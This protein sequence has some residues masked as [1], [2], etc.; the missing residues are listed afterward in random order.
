MFLLS[1]LDFP[2]VSLLEMVSGE[3]NCHPM[4]PIL[5]CPVYLH[6]SNH[7]Q[8]HIEGTAIQQHLDPGQPC[9]WK[10]MM[11]GACIASTSASMG[12]DKKKE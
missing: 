5:A 7:P 2:P 10:S 12:N 6:P 4:E 1:A 3:R 8:C 9:E 11:L